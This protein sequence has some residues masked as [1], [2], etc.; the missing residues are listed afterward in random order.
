MIYL[1]SDHA[2]FELKQDVARMLRAAGVDITDLGAGELDPEDD[3]P[4][5]AF[6]VGEAVAEDPD[7]FGLFFCGSA[8]GV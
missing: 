6:A 5:Y 3:Y 2:G 8:Q 7:G 4:I 1:G